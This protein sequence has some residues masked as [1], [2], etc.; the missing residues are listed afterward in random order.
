MYNCY[1]WRITKHFFKVLK[2]IENLKTVNYGKIIIMLLYNQI[3]TENIT[4]VLL[5]QFIVKIILGVIP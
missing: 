5:V 1:K 4:E 2:Q 3:I